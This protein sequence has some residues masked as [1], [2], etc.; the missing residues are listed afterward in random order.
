[1]SV[2]F[3]QIAED[4]SQKF[5]GT[6]VHVAFKPGEA[7]SLFQCTEVIRHSSS[8]PTLSLVNKAHGVV[9]LNY[10]TECE[11][12]FPFPKCGYFW[13][14]NTIAAIFQRRHGRQ[15]RRGIC[16]STASI[17]TPYARYYPLRFGINEDTLQSAFN[18]VYVTLDDAEKFI[19]SAQSLSVPL[20]PYLALGASPSTR[21]NELII[22]F[23][24]KPIATYTNGIIRVRE[25]QFHQ[26]IVDFVKE[27]GA[28]A[29]IV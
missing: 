16:S 28:N 23:L 18:P 24:G 10:Q 3:R 27:S 11:V 20:S 1:M 8:A 22:W 6:F 2:N 15:Y 9:H 26:E 19:A 21:H 14:D 5:A 13:V 29:Q 4:F 17:T 12:T 7:P 25:A